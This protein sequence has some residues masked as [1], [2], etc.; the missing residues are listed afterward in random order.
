VLAG[1]LALLAD[2]LIRAGVTVREVHNRRG[3][4]A[5]IRNGYAPFGRQRRDRGQHERATGGISPHS[6]GPLLRDTHWSHVAADSSLHSTLWIAEWPRI[7][8]RATFLQEL[9]MGTHATRERELAAGH[10]AVR[11]AGYITLSVPNDGPNA[12][13]ELHGTVS[14][15]EMAANRASLRLERMWGQ[16]DE[17]LTFTLP[18]CRGLQ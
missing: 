3:L 4:A 9:L 16:Q 10:A 2:Q 8:V 18:L 5:A 14:R 11:F 7:D 6:A 15:A 1:E 17:A 12:L 13:D